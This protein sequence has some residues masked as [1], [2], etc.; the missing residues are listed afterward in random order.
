[1]LG[2]PSYRLVRRQGAEV[3]VRS[4][5]T[6]PGDRWVQRADLLVRRHEHEHAQALPDQ[7][8]DDVQEAREALADDRLCVGRQQLAG[9]LQHEQPPVLRRAA[10]VLGILVLTTDRLE[11]MKDR[12][13]AEVRPAPAHHVNTHRHLGRLHQHGHQVVRALAE[14]RVRIDDVMQLAPVAPLPGERAERVRLAGA[15]NAVPEDQLAAVRGLEIAHDRVE[16]DT[17][18]GCVVAPDLV[19]L[20]HRDRPQRRHRAVRRVRPKRDRHVVTGDRLRGRE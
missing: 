9:V 4:T 10:A 6:R 12:A 5:A 2:E 15:R 14:E 1:M 18:L 16:V 17:R 19:P 20:G 11:L 8:V 7:P 13:R 3:D